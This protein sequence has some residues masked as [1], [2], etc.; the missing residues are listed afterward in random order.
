VGNLYLP[1][2]EH[3]AFVLFKKFTENVNSSFFPLVFLFGL[4]FKPEFI[5]LI[6]L[7]HRNKIPGYASLGQLFSH[8]AYLDR[9]AWRAY[10]R[11]CAAL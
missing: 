8:P 6:V 4:G 3:S 7:N 11:G 5:I 10:I 1:I 2:I 9:R